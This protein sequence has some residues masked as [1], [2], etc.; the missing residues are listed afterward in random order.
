[1]VD[2]VIAGVLA[3]S[4]WLVVEYLAAK[5]DGQLRRYQVFSSHVQFD[6]RLLEIAR[7]PAGEKESAD[8]AA[9][10]LNEVDRMM[11]S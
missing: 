9:G 1:M 2:K 11:K 6:N 7:F 4:E 8:E 10:I 3:R 5:E